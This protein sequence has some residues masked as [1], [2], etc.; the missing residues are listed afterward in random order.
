MKRL[1]CLFEASTVGTYDDEV[2]TWNANQP[3]LT[4]SGF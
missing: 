2:R 3:F 1:S 4:N